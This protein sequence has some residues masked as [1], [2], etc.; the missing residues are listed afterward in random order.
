MDYTIR[1]MK[2]EDIEQVQTVAKISWHHTYDG[3]IPFAIQDKF[4]QSAY[5]SGMLKR[6]ME[7]S[8]LFVA[9]AEGKV[10]GFA[11]YSSVKD[12]GEVELGAI[13]L[14][15]DYQ[16]QQ[17]GTALLQAGIK[18]SPNVKKVFINVE[19]D[20]Q[21]GKNFYHAKGFKIVA[22]FEEN[23]DGYMLQTIRM[24]LEV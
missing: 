24:V 12:N 21:T 4:L 17:I 16:G 19:K 5:N 8:F 18:N 7:F 23:F 9:E 14:L 20:N 15:P 22:S 2:E 1:A 3:I 6:R 10:V 11:N 13:Y